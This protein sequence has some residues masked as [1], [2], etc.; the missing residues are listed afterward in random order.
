MTTNDKIPQLR[1]LA[2]ENFHEKLTRRAIFK[3]GSAAAGLALVVAACG[4]DDNVGF[5]RLEP[6]D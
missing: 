5:G 4:G 2:P 3:M 6:R 1:M